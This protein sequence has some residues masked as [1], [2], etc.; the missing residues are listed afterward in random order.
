MEFIDLYELAAKVTKYEK[1]LKEESQKRK[2]SMGTYCQEV[3]SEKITVTELLST[4]FFI[5]HLL[6]KKALDLWKKSHNFN[7]QVQYNFDAT[8]IEEIFDFLLKNKF[9]TFPHDHQLPSKEELRGKV[10]Y[11][12]RNSWN[13]GTNSCW[14]F[15]NII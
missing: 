13:H 8:K 6:V 7:T 2:T 10:Y 4:G 3:N 9:I 14:S 12:Y 1:S 5:Y 15:R 11:K